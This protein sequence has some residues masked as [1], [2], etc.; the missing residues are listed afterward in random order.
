ML[1]GGRSSSGRAVG[2]FCS[3]LSLKCNR[4]TLPALLLAHPSLGLLG[5]GVGTGL[6]GNPLQLA[7]P[8]M[9]WTFVKYQSIVLIIGSAHISKKKIQFHP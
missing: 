7:E 2:P 9:V 5:V 1:L 6:L 4:H 3:Y 8:L